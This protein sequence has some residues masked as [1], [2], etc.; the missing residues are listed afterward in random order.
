MK[1]PERLNW[2]QGDGLIPAIVQ[3]AETG[4]VLMLAYMNREALEKT[5][6]TRRVWFYSRSR[7]QLWMKGETSG[8]VLDLVSICTD[9]DRD[10]LL[11][12]VTPR[13]PVCHRGST[14][15]FGREKGG[16]ILGE[17]Y[18]VIEERREEKPEG[19]YTTALF[20]DG[21]ERVCAKVSEESH[22]VIQAAK[23]ETRERLIEETVDLLYHLFVLLVQRGVR[24]PQLLQEVRRRRES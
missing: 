13:G 9:C 24:L 6:E 4:A 8:N 22:E 3:D 11:V 19:S 20:R 5:V 10:T 2:Q 18:R 14:S 7:S 16:G 15:C 21:P 1:P 23:E 12:E 17:L